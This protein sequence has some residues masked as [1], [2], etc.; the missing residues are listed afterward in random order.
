[1]KIEVL[2]SADIAMDEALSTIAS[3]GSEA[4]AEFEERLRRRVEA[5]DAE[6]WP[7]ALP[8][9]SLM[10]DPSGQDVCP[11]D[12][13]YQPCQDP[14]ECR[15]ARRGVNLERNLAAIM[16]SGSARRS[17]NTPSQ[18]SFKSSKSSTPRRH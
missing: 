9:G 16:R 6:N 10:A 4:L 13:H 5:H 15:K 11:H 7:A 17:V 3:Y 12:V 8:P 18:R 2:S 1:M 14:I